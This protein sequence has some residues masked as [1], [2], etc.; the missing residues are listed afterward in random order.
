MWHRRPAGVVRAPGPDPTKLSRLPSN[1]VDAT[2]R[3]AGLIPVLP[4]G[5]KLPH[6]CRHGREAFATPKMTGETLVRHRREVFA[7]LS[8][9]F[10]GVQA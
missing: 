5:S 10:I 9:H 1:V 7:L 4:C 2:R 8:I 3:A 6:S